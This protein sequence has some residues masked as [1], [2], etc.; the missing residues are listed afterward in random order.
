MVGSYFIV[1]ATTSYRHHNMIITS[2][3]SLF[4]FC[5]W[6]SISRGILAIAPEC[7]V[8]ISQCFRLVGLIVFDL[9]I[10]GG[11]SLELNNTL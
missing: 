9:L 4:F 10:G 1:F 5:S 3:L 6:K 2:D 8:R 11:G 7:I